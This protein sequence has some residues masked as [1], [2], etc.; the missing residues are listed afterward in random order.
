VPPR[1][2]TC[3]LDPDSCDPRIRALANCGDLPDAEHAA[4]AAATKHPLSTELQ[5]LH[6]VLLV[7]LGRFRDAA[8]ALRRVIYLDRT[9]VVVHLA[10]GSVL[11]RLGD[12]AGARRAY[13]NGQALASSAPA[14][15]VVPLSDGETAGRL[16]AAAEAQI[17]MLDAPATRAG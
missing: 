3:E 13:R 12:T 6:A 2:N 11:H 17:A 4:A 1:A 7:D 9:L 15:A 14:D 16:A 8:E 5:F 10:L